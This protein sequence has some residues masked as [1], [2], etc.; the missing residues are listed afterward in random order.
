LNSLDEAGLGF[1]PEVVFPDAKDAPAG[2]AQGAVDEFIASLV[3]G[4]FAPPE[5]A[6]VF[7][8][9]P[10]FGAIMPETAVHEEGQAGGA[11]H[12]V[13]PHTKGGMRPVRP[14]LASTGCVTM[15]PGRKSF[16][17]L[18]GEKAG[19]RAGVPQSDDGMATPAGDFVA[20]QEAHEGNFGFLVA[21]A[22]DAGH[23][24]GA[25][26]PGEDV[27]HSN[28]KLSGKYGRGQFGGVSS[29]TDPHFHDGRRENRNISPCI[30]AP[31]SFCIH[32]QQLH[33]RVKTVTS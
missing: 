17:L 16:H 15:Q 2:A 8:F 21:A 28:R 25:F 1:G 7:G 27:R 22:A 33:D 14:I 24:L 20:A 29:Q 23:H 10:V 5:G 4:K 32:F 26:L 11:E 9:G 12:E 30:V 19:M 6:I 18:L 3:G 13:R 31:M